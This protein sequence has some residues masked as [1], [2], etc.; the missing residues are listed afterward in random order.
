LLKLPTEY[1]VQENWGGLSFP[2]ADAITGSD[3]R[4]P[5]FVFAQ[6]EMIAV[7]LRR[8]RRSAAV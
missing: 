6:E 8:A 3:R 1:L 4:V 7:W 2:R 5:E